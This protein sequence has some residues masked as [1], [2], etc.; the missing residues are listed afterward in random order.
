MRHITFLLFFISAL[1]FAKTDKNKK[2]N[3]SST[4]K[5]VT[6]YLS[7]AQIERIATIKL[8]KGTTEFV[9]NKLS[10]NIQESSIQISGLKSASILSVNFGINYLSKQDNS[11]EVED[12]QQR[13][14]DLN[15]KYISQDNII[16]GYNEE[17]YLIQ[18]NRSLGNTTQVVS[19]EKLQKFSTYFRTRITEI[20]EKIQESTSVKS[21]LSAQISDLKKQL[22]ELNVD[23]KVQTGEIKI[24]LNTEIATDLN[25]IIKYN[26]SEAG[27]FPIYDI[28]AEKIN[29]PLQL[30]YKAHV[31]Q[32]TGNDW[33]NVKLTLSTSDP[34]TNNVKPNIDP[35]YLNFISKHS[36]YNS[37]RATKSY[38]YKYNPLVKTVSGVVTSSSDGLP[39]PGVNVIE[40]GTSNG[41]QTDF[42]GNYTIKT[43]GGKDLQ[44]S[45]IGMQ[46]ETLPIHSSIMNVTMLEDLNALDE[47][48]ITGYA[49]KNSKS[50]LS[51][52][53]KTISIDELLQGQTAGLNI[54][55]GNGQPGQSANV[56]IRGRNSLNGDTEPLFIIDGV[57]VDQDNFR[58]LNQNDIKD[59]K[60]LKNA[61]ATALYG[62]R[63]AGG[64]ILISTKEG[65]FTSNGDF[66]E[67]GITNTRFEISKLHSIPT[68]GDVTVIEIENYEVP[69]T[70]SYFAAP[71][72]NENVFLT[73]EIEN[74][75]Q[76]NL[77]PAEANVY[78]EGSYS[79]KTNINPQSTTE[80]LTI[81]LG[82]D[83]NVVVK[84]TQPTD[85][86]KNAFIGS[87]KIISK[88]YEIELK[89]NKSSAIDLV[90]YD[91]IPIS[92]NKDIKIDDIET[93]RSNY[94]DKKGILKWTL[95][96][97]TNV[98][99]THKFSYTVKY[100]KYKR[101]NL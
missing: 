58:E 21:D 56:I 82:V 24:K 64:V 13:I 15:N 97:D 72:L 68:S 12:I 67:E 87:N 49:G 41:V 33:N 1:C 66:I 91:R 69:A 94:D 62:N 98:K 48:V 65:D 11:Q 59:M 80:K 9:F 92:Q 22:N 23:E 99:E 8:A 45:F 28:K 20:K 90:L 55:T 46:S 2:N 37:N 19:L 54:S 60:V 96:L 86:K 71:V 53:V 78:F 30:A 79:G 38:N 101:V 100:P 83:P 89:N 51:S 44:Y 29:K 27:W 77:L 47:V 63:G 3:T 32:N 4:L 7:G 17:L 34:N 43:K 84:R 57:P 6:V 18:Q 52:A 25:L 95:K 31:Y 26:V 5:E 35:K 74:W 14:K 16:T 36:N 42:D 93:G 70:Y 85:F 88:Q 75:E 40:K 76:Y 81:S 39:L 50:K 73:A 10:P 61:S